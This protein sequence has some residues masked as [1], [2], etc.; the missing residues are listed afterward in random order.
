MNKFPL[1]KNL[2]SLSEK[3]YDRVQKYKE[4]LHTK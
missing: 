3:A 1:G 4:K 2:I